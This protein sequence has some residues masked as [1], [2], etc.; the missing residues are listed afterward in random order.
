[1]GPRGKGV[2]VESDNSSRRTSTRVG[3]VGLWGS[4]ILVVDADSHLRFRHLSGTLVSE[5]LW[6]EVSPRQ[7][8]V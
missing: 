6:T 7:K 8:R 4:V 1:M 2:G 5:S 3:T